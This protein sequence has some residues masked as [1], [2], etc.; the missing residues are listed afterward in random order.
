MDDVTADELKER[1]G[2]VVLLDV[3]NETEYIGTAGYPCDARQGHIPTAR[4]LPLDRLMEA[5]GPE[6]IRALVGEPEGAEVIAYCHSGGRSAMAVQV[7]RGAGYAARN[8]A[9]SWH[10]WSSRAELPVE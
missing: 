6:E 7:L 10:D 4:H 9:G 2:Q 1:L 3:R 5:G 8:Y